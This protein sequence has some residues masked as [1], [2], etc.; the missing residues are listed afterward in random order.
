M[1][2]YSLIVVLLLQ[3]ELSGLGVNPFGAP[4]L[5]GIGSPGSPGKNN[6]GLGSTG[7]AA[8]Q[9]GA[10]F[11]GQVHKC[12]IPENIQYWFKN[13]PSNHTI[14]DKVFLCLKKKYA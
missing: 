2:V 3:L 12:Q 9:T 7:F 13:L 11:P 8:L 6:S 14:T 10:Q 4:V 5:S 1:H